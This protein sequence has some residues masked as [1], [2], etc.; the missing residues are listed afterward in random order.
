LYHPAC[1]WFRQSFGDLILHNPQPEQRH[2]Q[3]VAVFI[4]F[5]HFLADEAV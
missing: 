5:H 3:P 4:A 2:G 1:L